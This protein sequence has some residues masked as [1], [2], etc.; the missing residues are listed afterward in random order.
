MKLSLALKITHADVEW[1]LKYCLDSSYSFMKISYALRITPMLHMWSEPQDLIWILPLKVDF[2][3]M[4]RYGIRGR[5]ICTYEPWKFYVLCYFFLS[6]LLLLCQKM[7]VFFIE[8]ENVHRRE[9]NSSIESRFLS[10]ETGGNGK[11]EKR[12]R[13]PW[14]RLTG[15]TILEAGHIFSDTILSRK[16]TR[17]NSKKNC[18]DSSYSFRKLSLALWITQILHMWSGP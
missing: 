9:V 15:A 4:K 1:S 11:F 17:L 5:S 7:Q 2:W 10:Y 13:R 16:S 12:S 6:W 18:L 3:V 14:D 8:R